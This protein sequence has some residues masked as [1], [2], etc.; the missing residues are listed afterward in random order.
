MSQFTFQRSTFEEQEG[1]FVSSKKQKEKASPNC[2]RVFIFIFQS[3]EVI[4]AGLF[5]RKFYVRRF[6]FRWEMFHQKPW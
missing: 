3:V 6:L 5:P 2:F 1:S 4:E